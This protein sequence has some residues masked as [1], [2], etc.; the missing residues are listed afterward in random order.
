MISGLLAGLDGLLDRLRGGPHERARLGA[1]DAVAVLACAVAA[2]AVSA[3]S[4]GLLGDVL[5]TEGSLDIW[6]QADSPRVVANLLDAGSSQYRANVHPIF[7]ILFTPWLSALAGLGGSPLLWG[8]AAVAAAGA[9][10]VAAVFL[11]LR[12][13]GLPRGVALV[14]AATFLT[15]ATYLHWYAVIEIG[16][17]SGLS[18]VLAVLA[19][20]MGPGRRWAGWPLM[21]A[22]TLGVT[23]TN[24]T[25]GLAATIARWPLRKAILISTV[26]LALTAGLAVG[27]RFLYPTAGLFFDPFSLAKER[28]YATPHQWSPAAN[29][30]ALVLYSAVTPEPAV[31]RRDGRAIVSNQQ[32]PVSAAGWAG[33]VAILAWAGCLAAGVWGAVRTPQVRPITFGLG[34]MLEIG[35]AHV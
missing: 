17:F 6:F 1:P 13:T 29:L 9:L 8:K 16:A 3:W 25:A 27:Q 10:S 34:L 26:A 20:A 31:E 14:F 30:R 33:M 24:W 21:S 5:Y 7:P 12:F 2:V 32:V 11:A 28:E 35:R 19:L 4:M 22:F 23:I 18:I 15:S